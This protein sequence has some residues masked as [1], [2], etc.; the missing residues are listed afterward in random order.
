MKEYDYYYFNPS[1]TN[2]SG[3]TAM[4]K[5]LVDEAK[6]KHSYVVYGKDAI[7]QVV[8]ELK[9]RAE[10]LKKENPRWKMPDISYYVSDWT[11]DVLLSI[12]SWSFVCYKVKSII[13]L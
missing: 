12:D 5:K 11:G 13:R 1:F 2:G 9:A 6:A 8:A 4:A 3:L 10:E 7:P